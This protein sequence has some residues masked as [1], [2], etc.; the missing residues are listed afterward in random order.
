MD[1]KY[2][3]IIRAEMPPGHGTPERPWYWYTNVTEANEECAPAECPRPA[4]MGLVL[5]KE[6]QKDAWQERQDTEETMDADVVF[7]CAI[8]FIPAVARLTEAPE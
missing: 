6:E 8:H 3:D 4:H 7:Y 1:I 5:M 2:R